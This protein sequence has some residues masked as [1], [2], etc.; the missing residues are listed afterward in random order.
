[1]SQIYPRHRGIRRFSAV[2]RTGSVNFRKGWQKH[3]LLPRQLMSRRC[4]ASMITSIG[5]AGLSLDDFDSNGV[6]LPGSE[7]IAFD[8]GLPLHRGPHKIYNE[9]VFER[10]GAVEMEWSRTRSRDEL[11]ARTA[12]LSRLQL[13]QRGLARRI[14]REGRSRL[15]LS[16]RDPIGRGVDYSSLDAMAEQLWGATV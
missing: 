5:S 2:N 13:V 16:R 15:T 11:Q 12:A 6:L 10:V 9:L 4:L 7:V 1:M 3:H 14:E 8:E